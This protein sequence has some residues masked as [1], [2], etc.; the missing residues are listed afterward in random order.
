MDYGHLH[1]T[2]TDKMSLSTTTKIFTIWSTSFLKKIKEDQSNSKE[3][4]VTRDF[5]FNGGKLP[6]LEF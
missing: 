4:N 2:M 1:A 3:S 6:K 5:F